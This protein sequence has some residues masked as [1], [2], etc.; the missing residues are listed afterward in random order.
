MGLAGR[1]VRACET[2]KTVDAALLTVSSPTQRF[3]VDSY[4]AIDVVVPNAGVAEKVGWLSDEEG[5][6]GEPVVSSLAI[7][8]SIRTRR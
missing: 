3:A 1:H 7:R 8:R 5:P 4:G 2:L 6:D